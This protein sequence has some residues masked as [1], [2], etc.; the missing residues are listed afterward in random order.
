VLGLLYGT[1]PW[2]SGCPPPA[3][4]SDRCPPT[5]L[6]AWERIVAQIV[7]R[8]PEIRYW[9]V[10]NEADHVVRF[11][12]DAAAYAAIL[13]A[14][15]R[16]ARRAN[17]RARV[18]FTGACCREGWTEEVLAQGVGGSY[19]IANAH[20][21]GGVG[22]LDDMTRKALGT[23]RAAG[24]RGPLWVTET[25]YPSDAAYQWDAGFTG[26]TAAQARYL[27]AA[28]P[29]MLGA[30]A[31]RVFITLRD[32]DH[33]WG[34]FGSEGI[35]TWP[36]HQAKLSFFTVRSLAE[37][38]IRRAGSRAARARALRGSAR[39]RARLRRAQARRRD[40]ARP[41]SSASR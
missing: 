4:H 24:F 39:A 20:F 33:A 23:F 27:A 13:R 5:D 29:A 35:L 1:P 22:K 12:G 32:T 36:R 17:P 2:L 9:E 38:L 19:D 15:S 37:R 14:T 6:A 25:G 21:R 16:A 34:I 3:Q 26:G 28:V 7:A 31:Q 11:A 40:S 41:A 10:L 8:A 18:V 30:G